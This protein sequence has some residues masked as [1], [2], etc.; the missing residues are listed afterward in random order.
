MEL[1]RLVIG[2]LA[3][4]LTRKTLSNVIHAT[5]FL[6]FMQSQNWNDYICM[7]ATK[8]GH[9]LYNLIIQ[10]PFRPFSDG[11]DFVQRIRL[12]SGEFPH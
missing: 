12:L 8:V 2:I 4:D 7:E 6:L 9:A 1:G 10:S 11:A 3:I 5:S